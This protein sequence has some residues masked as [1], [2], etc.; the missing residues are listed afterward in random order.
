MKKINMLSKTD[1]VKG[2][3]VLSAHDE[4]VALVRQV[5]QNRALILE[6]A[7]TASEIT[8]YHSINPE[9]YLSVGKR[10]KQGATVGYVHFL[11]ETVENSIS[12]P[13]TVKQLFYK[14]MISFYKRMD[15]LVTVNPL[16]IDKLVQYGVPREK[17]TYIPNVVSEETFYPASGERREKI[18]K[19]CHIAPETFTVL[20]VGQLQKRKGVF[21][22]VETARRMPDCQFVWAEASFLERYQK[23]MKK[24]GH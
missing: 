3:G 1:M 17:I 19:K 6:N 10:K 2:Q 24:F 21:E 8:H 4:Q 16:F 14:Y 9:Y 5:M 11:P 15:Y 13:R 18:R 22:F 23:A 20:C 12:L 7:K